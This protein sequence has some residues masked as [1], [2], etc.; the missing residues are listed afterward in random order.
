[1]RGA[2]YFLRHMDCRRPR[3][4]RLPRLRAAAAALW[5][6]ATPLGGWA[7]NDAAPDPADPQAGATAQEL[8]EG[9]MKAFK[10][11]DYA[12]AERQLGAFVEGYAQNP[13]AAEAVRESRAPLALCKVKLAKFADAVPLIDGALNDKKLPGEAAEE[14][15]FLKGICHIKLGEI[16][17]AQHAFGQ[18]WQNEAHDA[19]RR[20]EALI[21]FGT[22][23]LMA[24][25]FPKGAAFFQ[26]QIPV[27][28]AGYPAGIEAAGR[29]K[30][31][32]LHALLEAGDNAAALD[33]IRAQFLRL[34]ELTQIVSFQ[35]LAL[36]LGSQLLEDGDFHGA[37]ACLQRIWKRDRLLRHQ[38]DKLGDM[39]RRRA[40]FAARPNSASQV[41]Q[42]DGT[43]K[44]IE[45]EIANFEGIAEFDA[46]L[47][48][49][50][51]SAFRGL[52]R[53]REAGLILADMLE[54]LPPGP[55][56]EGAAAS[57]VQ[58]WL[59]CRRWDDAA[60]AADAFLE[61]FGGDAHP[62]AAMIRFLKAQALF[63]DR[64]FPEAARAFA[65]VPEN[66][67]DAPEAPRADFMAAMAM[68]SADQL[69]EARLSLAQFP[70]AFPK[71]DLKEDAFYWEGMAM[72]FAKDHLGARGRMA[73]YAETYPSGQY[74]ASAKFRHAFSTHALA[75]YDEAV[76]EFSAFLEAHPAAAEGGEA[77]LLRGDAL[78]AL[79]RIDEGTES[80]R[81]ID[82]AET[83]FYE[84]GYFKI[85]KALKLLDKMPEM[86]AHFEAFVGGRPGSGRMPE[87]VYWIGQAL[88]A[89]GDEA[90]AEKIYWDTVAKT[91]PDPDIRGA[92]DL[93]E[94]MARLYTAPDEARAFAAKLDTMIGEAH[95]AGAATL[96]L[97]LRW[98]RA[99]ALERTAPKLAEAA[100][101]G[102]GD[103]DRS[104]DPQP[105][106]HRGLRRCAAG[107]R[108]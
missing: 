66:F 82:P 105:A 69:D 71:S 39:R 35:S 51:A 104:K 14:L 47:R 76:A 4:A 31:L 103:L 75:M 68:L 100:L 83:K 58:C 38:R 92:E 33:L 94:G 30:T 53:Y 86:Q 87:A 85:G 55:V 42:L 107:G 74:E 102:C 72:S 63:E 40:V 8:Y 25:D 37:I 96:E 73:A 3:I 17:A 12:G 81:S 20:R 13:D 95:A 23:Y 64:R 6:A 98:A 7:Q 97:R 99:L 50:L 77:K 32:L 10:D 108:L 80:Y 15:R 46:A 29:A 101:S 54:S 60:A 22:G 36:K 26:D 43:I 9:G 93:L 57:L 19:A 65:Y 70:N 2:P 45:R 89:Q 56:L 78:Y 62:Q 11:G 67:P 91:A 59:A 49:R 1:M 27:L 24:S 88:R 44:R 106:D 90:G 16:V 18:F 21:L 52:D 28:E 48:L 34:G 84:D 41:F 61:K 79:G 5:L